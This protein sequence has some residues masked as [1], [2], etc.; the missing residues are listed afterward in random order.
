MSEEILH[1]F[2]SFHEETTAVIQEQP[3]EPTT[4]PAVSVPIKQ[5]SLYEMIDGKLPERKAIPTPRRR[6]SLPGR[7][8]FD[9]F[10]EAYAFVTSRP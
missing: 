10:R 1:N 7:G 5:K 2:T 8:L 3:Q 4:K 9:A 6:D